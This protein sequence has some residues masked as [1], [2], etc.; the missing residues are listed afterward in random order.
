MNM[1]L[2]TSFTCIGLN[3]Q[4]DLKK[5]VYLILYFKYIEVENGC[6]IAKI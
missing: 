4:K 3:K 6:I 1:K 5:A 2:Y